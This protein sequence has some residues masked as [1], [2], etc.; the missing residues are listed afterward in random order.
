MPGYLNTVSGNNQFVYGVINNPFGPGTVFEPFA[1]YPNG[2]LVPQNDFS[3]GGPVFYPPWGDTSVGPGLLAADNAG[4]VAVL[5]F[6][7]GPGV[8][9]EEQ[10]AT[11]TIQPNGSLVS[12]N[13]QQEMPR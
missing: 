4:H 10:F 5:E 6:L 8:F 3:T 9:R 1:I 13:L 11:Y 12:T 2:L 7:Y